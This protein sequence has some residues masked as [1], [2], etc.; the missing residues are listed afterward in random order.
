MI[1]P[2]R[3]ALLSYVE[4][5]VTAGLGLLLFGE[6]LAPIQIAGIALVIGALVGSTLWPRSPSKNGG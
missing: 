4:P 2:V 1:G 5:V 3:A 6:M